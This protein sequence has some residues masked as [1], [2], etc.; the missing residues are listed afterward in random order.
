MKKIIF[1]IISFLAIVISTKAQQWQWAYNEGGSSGT[2]IEADSYG[3]IFV[4]ASVNSTVYGAYT[5]PCGSAASA[6]AKHDAAGNILWARDFF[7]EGSALSL[8][9]LGNVYITGAFQTSSYF[10]GGSNPNITVTTQGGQID[11]FLCKYSNNGDLQWVKTWGT[12]SSNDQG[13][14]I[15]TDLDGNSYVT[16]QYFKGAYQGGPVYN[17]FLRKYNPQGNLLWEKTSNWNGSIYPTCV[18]LDVNGNCYVGG[19]FRDSAYFGNVGI[20]GNSFSSIFIT[21]YN[22]NGTEIWTKKDGTAHDDCRALSFDSKS[23]FFITGSHYG[24]SM[25]GSTTLLNGGVFIAKYDTNGVNLWAKNGGGKIGYSVVADTAGNC[26]ITGFYSG[27]VIFGSGINSTTL[28]TQKAGDIYAAKYDKSG[29]FRWAVSPGGG[30]GA[31][32]SGAAITSDFSNNYYVIG[33]F[34]GTT[35]FGSYPLNANSGSWPY[36]IFLAKLKDSSE[37][38]TG[39]KHLFILQ[40]ELII[41]PNPALNTINII[42][43]N[44]DEISNFVICI[45]NVTGQEIYS[46]TYK[47]SDNEFN[48]NSATLSASINIEKYARGVYLIEIN[49]DGKRSVKMIILN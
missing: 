9:K 20:L 6:I 2:D 38:L 45:R 19:N 39:D 46:K 16:G 28:V 5:F 34:S 40:N 13:N 41:F 3:N 29:N 14:A 24:S 48:S 18:G 36:D 22:S 23:N 10:C 8:D 21:K 47:N 11:A 30:P 4:L 1:S 37:V 26:V 42:Y 35:I 15:R 27:T 31:G 25:F 44:S 17:Y 49:A 32:N 12:T 33:A 43:K 7:C